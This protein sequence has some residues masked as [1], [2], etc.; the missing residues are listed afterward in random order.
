[1]AFWHQNILASV[2]SQN[3]RKHIAIVS[4]S[5]DGDIAVNVA[6]HFG[7]IFVRGSSSRNGGK[8]LLEMIKKISVDGLPGGITIDGPRG[9]SHEVPQG[10]IEL[11]KFTKTP[12]LPLLAYP[13]KFWSL[14]SW[15]QFRIPKP[16]S[17]IHII[18]AKPIYVPHDI[19]KEDY[20]FYTQAVKEILE[21]EE[22][23]IIQKLKG[24]INV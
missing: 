9:P 4:P 20:S 7:Y 22:N 12:I 5:K 2:I 1:M 16:F 24:K 11:A 8:A 14:N 13:E 6:K 10:V 3:H 17:R 23:K 19:T 21:K 15:D 18:Y